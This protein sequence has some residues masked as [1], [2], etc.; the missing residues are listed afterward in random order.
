SGDASLVHDFEER[1]LRLRPRPVDLVEE[2]DVGEDRSGDEVERVR[3]LVVDRRPGDVRREEVARALDTLEARVDRSGD[4]A[5]EH[6]L[7]DAGDVLD[8]EVDPPEQGAHGEFDGFTFAGDDAFD[9]VDHRIHRSG[10]LS[11]IHEVVG[12]AYPPYPLVIGTEGGVD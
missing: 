3:L 11:E 2:N 7:A 10:R 12:G 1:R 6:R 9:G 4:S 5:G 8:E